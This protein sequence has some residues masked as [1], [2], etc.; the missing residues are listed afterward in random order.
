[1][2]NYGKE[3]NVM[4]SKYPQT[5]RWPKCSLWKEC[6]VES[7]GIMTKM[8]SF[9]DVTDVVIQ[10]IQIWRAWRSHIES[11][12]ILKILSWVNFWVKWAM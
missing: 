5:W 7:G 8:L 4:Q 12:M 10:A 11:Y 3:K 1:M 6:I 2:F 9:N